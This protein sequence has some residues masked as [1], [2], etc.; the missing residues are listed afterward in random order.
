MQDGVIESHVWR[1]VARGRGRA[2]R[3]A[4]HGALQRARRGRTAH[5]HSTPCCALGSGERRVESGMRPL[6]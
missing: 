6:T 4:L 1:G 2:R 5:H 3:A